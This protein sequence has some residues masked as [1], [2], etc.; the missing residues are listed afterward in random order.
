MSWRSH[1]DRREVFRPALCRWLA[2]VAAVLTLGVACAAPDARGP[3]ALAAS[4]TAPDGA[5][6]LALNTRRIVLLRVTLLGDT[7][8]ERAAMASAAL[9]ATFDR[10]GAGVVTRTL[11]DNVVR[12]ELDGTTLFYLAAGDV[13]G[14]RTPEMLDA[15]AQKVES[16]LRA[17]LAEAR[18]MRDPRRIGLATAV[19]AAASA[20]AWIVARLL[21]AL[22]RHAVVRLDLQ[23]ERWQAAHPS[24]SIARTTLAMR[25][26]A[27][28]WQPAPLPG[29][30]CCCWPTSG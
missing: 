13:G 4:T 28:A 22:R 3:G 18:E 19:V 20:I 30:W 17:A 29:C 14:V 10:G 8:V 6:V 2:G 7:A 9:D 16:H 25:N 23:L 21:L 24:K 15:A 1:F 12:F 11:V 26:R 5:A 27:A